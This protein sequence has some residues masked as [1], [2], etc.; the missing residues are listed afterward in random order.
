MTKVK[1]SEQAI[2]YLE[3]RYLNKRIDEKIE[4]LNYR[5]RDKGYQVELVNEINE[6]VRI[7]S[8]NNAAN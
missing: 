8:E 7:R 2:E 6:L 4:L 5:L 1:L 3:N